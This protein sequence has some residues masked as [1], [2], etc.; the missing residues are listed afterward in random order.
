MAEKKPGVVARNVVVKIEYTLTV[1]GEVVDT[2]EEEGPLEYLHGHGNIVDGLENA[3]EGKKIGDRLQVSVPPAEGYGEYDDEAQ[4]HVPRLELPADI[5]A[6]EGTELVI[7]DEDGDFLQAVI[8]WVGA[9]EVRLDFNHPLAG[10]ALDFDV[11]VVGLRAAT[12]EELDHGHAHMEGH[13]H[14]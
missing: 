11:E 9:D 8:T 12:S 1:D 7:E 6:E 4:A 13:E 5:P 3:L 14:D 10:Y 2:S